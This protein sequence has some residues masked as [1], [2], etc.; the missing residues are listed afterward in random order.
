[1]TATNPLLATNGL[2]QFSAIRPEHV[3]PAVDAVLADYRARIDA[4][5]ASDAPRDFASV[6]LLGEELEDRLN[7]VWARD[8]GAGKPGRSAKPSYREKV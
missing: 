7:H 6:V 3:E 1:M 5:L 4:L 8:N 2:P